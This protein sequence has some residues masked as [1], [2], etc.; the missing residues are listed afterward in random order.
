[1]LNEQGLGSR[2]KINP[3]FIGANATMVVADNYLVKARVGDLNILGIFI[4]I[5]EVRDTTWTGIEHH[6]ITLAGRNICSQIGLGRR[7][8]CGYSLS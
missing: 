4:S 8:K 6:H 7:I 2:N 1:M 3:N 5:P